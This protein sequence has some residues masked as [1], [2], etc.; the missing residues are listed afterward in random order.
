MKL[1]VVRGGG[2][3]GIASR[4]EVSTDSLSAEQARTLLEKVN[5]AGVLRHPEGDPGGVQH[6]DDLLYELTVEA[7]GRL[8][9]V[10]L[11]ESSLPEAVRSLIA[12]VDSV[13]S[14]QHTVERPGP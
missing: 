5:Q 14:A 13:P 9:T 11:S 1:S 2:I 8:H 3:A 6:P 12:W 4:T 10:R 7:E